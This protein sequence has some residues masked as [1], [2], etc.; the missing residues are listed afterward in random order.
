MTYQV[1]TMLVM[2]A[3][4]G[5]KPPGL[6]SWLPTEIGCAINLTSLSAFLY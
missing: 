1:K 4:G 2:N 6:V 3:D 5:T